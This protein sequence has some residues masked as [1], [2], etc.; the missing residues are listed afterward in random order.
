MFG[1]NMT[2]MIDC[3]FL[4]LIFFMTVSQISE[5]NF[6][7]L[8]LPTLK[9]SEDQELST[10]T[11]NV[12]EDGTIRMGGETVTLPGVVRHVTGE[13]AMQGNDPTRVTVVIR[14]DQR[15][16]SRTVNEIVRALN[17]MDIVR[18]RLAVQVPQ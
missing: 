14:A 11:I 10:I 12:M 6:E 18:V 2:P 4:L 15:S 8:Q 1:L 17:R 9:G 16:E 7:N 3:V 13:L 5:V